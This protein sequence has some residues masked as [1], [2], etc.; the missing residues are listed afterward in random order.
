MD[1]LVAHPAPRQIPAREEPHGIVGLALVFPSLA[2]SCPDY[3]QRWRQRPACPTTGT[4]SELR[5]A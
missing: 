4:T 3:R 2:H 1:S 5:K